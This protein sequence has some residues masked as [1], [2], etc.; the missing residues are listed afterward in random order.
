MIL[1]GVKTKIPEVGEIIIDGQIAP[2][3][4]PKGELN[5]AFLF[6]YF[7]IKGLLSIGRSFV[8]AQWKI[9]L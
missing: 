7:H 3:P 2:E 8:S 1:P 9:E 5:V 6:K 4:S